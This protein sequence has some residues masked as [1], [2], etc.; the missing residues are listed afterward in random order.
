MQGNDIGLLS[1]GKTVAGNRGD[2]IR[3]NATSH[4][5][6]IGQA[7]PVSSIDYYNAPVIDGMPVTGWQGLRNG[8]TS[9]QYLITGTLG[10]DG[11]LY[12]GPISGVGGTSNTFLVPGSTTTSVYGPNLLSDGSIQLVGTYKT[13]SGVV[14]GFLFQGTTADFSNPA[15]YQ[16]IDYPG[17]QYTYVHSTMGGLAVG[18]ADGPEGNAPV[19]TGTAFIYNIATGTYTTIAVPGRLSTTAYGIWYNGGTSYTIVGGYSDPGDSTN[20]LAHGYMVDYDVATG[21]FSNLA[22][23][24]P[25]AGLF[26]QN[27]ATHFEGI[28]SDEKGVYTLAA[29]TIQTASGASQAVVGDG[30]PQHRRLVRHGAM[31]PARRP[32]LQ[33]LDPAADDQQLRCRQCQRRHRHHRL[34]HLL[35]PGPGEHQLPALE[36]HRRQPRQRHRYLRRLV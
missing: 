7:D 28:S 35:V 5:D 33:R 10:A 14:N 30:P 25:P 22:S 18:N 19:G 12:E 1:D 31:G 11:L 17:A 15:D 9:G 16:T 32:R 23:F 27:V 20:G 2:G 8:A 34:G 3:I 4:G 26:G 29:T 21:Q 36:R 6:L 24:N 13:G